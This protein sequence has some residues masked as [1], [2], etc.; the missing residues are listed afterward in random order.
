MP[1]KWLKEEDERLK[2][3]CF[4]QEKHHW[5]IISQEFENK[6]AKQCRD[7]WTCY[8]KPDLKNQDIWTNEEDYLLVKLQNEIGNHWAKISKFFEGKSENSVKNRYYSNIRN[9]VGSLEG[10]EII[11]R[12]TIKRGN[13]KSIVNKLYDIFPIPEVKGNVLN[14]P[15]PTPYSTNSNS[16][17]ISQNLG[18]LN[19]RQNAAPTM[20]SLINC[21]PP[22]LVGLSNSTPVPI[23]FLNRNETQPKFLS[24]QIH[25]LF[26]LLPNQDFR[27]KITF[28]SQSFR[29]APIFIH[30]VVS[31]GGIF[32]SQNTPKVTSLINPGF[33]CTNLKKL[34]HC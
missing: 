29:P 30:P 4:G 5:T 14:V 9:R 2:S 25:P 13:T 18:G 7:R 8:L 31:T 34:F 22:S 3:L 6:T 20:V 10:N 23:N 33:I 17:P 16:F 21:V 24:T 26:N 32:E 12:K 28:L 11:L 27:P 15:N 19:F 1:D